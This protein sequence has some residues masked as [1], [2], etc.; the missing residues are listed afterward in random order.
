MRCLSM[1][2]LPTKY[3]S[4]IFY[5]W[6]WVCWGLGGGQLVISPLRAQEQSSGHLL[7]IARTQPNS[8]EARFLPK[9]VSEVCLPTAAIPSLLYSQPFGMPLSLGTMTDRYT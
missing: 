8:E 3:L 6:C 7:E 5:Y 4:N 1:R 9:R 2:C